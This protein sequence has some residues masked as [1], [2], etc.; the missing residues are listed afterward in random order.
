MNL[1]LNKELKIG[2]IVSE[3]EHKISKNGK[4]WA[5][6]VLEDYK[7]SHE[8]RIFGEEYLKY[9]HFLVDNSFLYL[10]LVVREGWRDKETGK[11]GEPRITY[12]SFQQ[13]QDAI[14]NNAKK[15]TLQLNLREFS[16]EKVED[17]KKIFKKHKGKQKLDI[18]F[19]ENEEK[20]KLTMPSENFKISINEDLLSAI[21]EKN[22]HF[23]L[24]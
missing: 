24:N 18:S 20:I 23:K 6:F 19:F 14:T 16:N 17:L 11:T 8:F 3:V 12:L 1:L 21:E 4:G 15:L 7:D 22:Y 5:R 13:L 9:Q 2:G 10:R